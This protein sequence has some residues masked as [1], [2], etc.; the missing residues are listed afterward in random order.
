ME[1]DVPKQFMEIGGKPVLIHTLQKFNRIPE[2]DRIILVASQDHLKHAENMTA[3]WGIRKISQLVAGGKERQDSVENGL[4]AVPDACEIVLVHD[5]V[6]PLVST[7][8][9][10]EVIQKTRE[11]GAAILAVPIKDTIKR[12]EDRMVEET[13]DRTKL[14]AVQTPQGFRIDL[15]REA[16][17]KA[18]EAGFYGT[19]D[20]VLVER[21][22][23]AVSIVEGEDCNIKITSPADL[24]WAEVML[25]REAP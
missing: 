9:I 15:I 3:E 14:W 21:L 25:S 22:G 10:H 18:K 19:D 8:K 4:E 13:L 23:H 17:R 5:G 6:R 24:R 20:A 7:E 1:S 12:G 16:Y 2:V 11:T